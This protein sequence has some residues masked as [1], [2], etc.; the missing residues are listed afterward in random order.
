MK[1]LILVLAGALMLGACS[2]APVNSTGAATAA[3]QTVAVMD[4]VRTQALKACAVVPPM[5]TSMI[6]IETS[7]PASSAS[8][9]AVAQ[10]NKLSTDVTGACN[11]IA[12]IPAPGAA[13]AFTL[14]DVSTFV[15][16]NVPTLLTIIGNSSMNQ[17]QK[18]AAQLTVVGVQTGLALAVAQ[19]Q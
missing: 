19:A 16:T 17:T 9:S 7:Q 2:V 10:L 1:R 3:S 18:T 6:T 13:P 14:S 12:K 15:N 8:T 4:N 5:I 11:L